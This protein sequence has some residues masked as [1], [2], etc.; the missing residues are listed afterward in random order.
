MKN[1]IKKISLGSALLI[2]SLAVV[3]STNAQTN[4]QPVNSSNEVRMGDQNKA[5]K[6][7]RTSTFRSRSNN[8]NLNAVNQSINGNTSSQRVNGR[9][10]K[11][12]NEV[13]AKNEPVNSNKENYKKEEKPQVITDKKVNVRSSRRPSLIAPGNTQKSNSSNGK[14]GN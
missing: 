2:L 3:D 1:T 11:A 9:N 5:N 7:N 10:T 14:S 8:A 4:R 13:D 6:V 12:K